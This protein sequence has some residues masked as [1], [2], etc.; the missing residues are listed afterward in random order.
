MNLQFRGFISS[1]PLRQT[2]SVPWLD[3]PTEQC[4]R[5]SVWRAISREPL[6]NCRSRFPRH[7][8]KAPS[9]HPHDSNRTALS[10][11]SLRGG[12]NHLCHGVP[13]RWRWS[14]R[15]G[16]S[17]C[18]DSFDPFFDAISGF[19]LCPSCRRDHLGTR[20]QW[21][22]GPSLL[23]ILSSVLCSHESHRR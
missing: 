10:A 23:K 11:A 17:E 1:D 5:P 4:I 22:E 2:A 19:A 8:G 13:Y 6:P 12:S 16:L 18:S 7:N 20:Y 3:S 21:S 15:L 9:G 14:E